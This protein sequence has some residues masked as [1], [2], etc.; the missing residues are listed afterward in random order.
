MA[1]EWLGPAQWLM[2]S[3]SAVDLV[4]EQNV[5]AYWHGYTEEVSPPLILATANGRTQVSKQMPIQVGPFLRMRLD[6]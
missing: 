1:K 6:R 5:P 2:D 3:G 4:S